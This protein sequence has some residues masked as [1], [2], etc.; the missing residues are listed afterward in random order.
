MLTTKW[1]SALRVLILDNSKINAL[2]TIPLVNL[3]YL[4]A[5][6]T[7]ITE[8]ST[9]SL[10]KIRYLWLYDVKIKTLEAHNMPLIEVL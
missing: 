1:L 6:K 7:V 9:V 2:D 4:S 10:G 8:L 3:E 5:S